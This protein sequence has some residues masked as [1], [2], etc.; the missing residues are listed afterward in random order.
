MK[1]YEIWVGNYHLGQG[2]HPPS[3][4]ELLATVESVDFKT[5]C[6]KYELTGKL[7]RINQGERQG[8]L[9]S[10]D[11][12]WWY[13]HHTNTNSWLGKYFET[14]QEAWSTFGLNAFLT[15]EPVN[16]NGIDYKLDIKQ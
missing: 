7:E 16:S 1:K 6:L 13:D 14:E 12:P 15:K 3:K 10:Q 9:N 8:N 4:P 5:A 2:S 11:Y